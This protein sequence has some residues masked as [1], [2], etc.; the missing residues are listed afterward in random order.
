MIR[1]ATPADFPFIH[2]IAARPDN[3]RF[4]VDV[5]DTEL[6]GNLADPEM[7]LVIWEVENS[8]AGF[9]LFCEIGN[10]SGRVEL[11]RLG[12]DRTGAGLGAAFLRA[13]I[14]HGFDGLNAARIW[15]DV[16]QDNP[17]AQATYTRVGFTHE[18]TLRQNWPRPT[19]DV[20]DM[21]VSGCCKT[22]DRNNAAA[23]APDVNPT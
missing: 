7:D 1:T 16:V 17:R 23:L 15:L 3:A 8:P 20:V 21:L 2:A 14:D 19:G 4:I 12:L 22:N 11:R 10:P 18:G 9:A 13:L 6:V 5:P